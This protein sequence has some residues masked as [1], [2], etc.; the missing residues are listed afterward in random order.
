MNILTGCRRFVLMFANVH[1]KIW[2]AQRLTKSHL[3]LAIVRWCGQAV[4]WP[5]FNF[6]PCALGNSHDKE[7]ERKR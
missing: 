3:I 4:K 5:L 6:N 1:A 2:C 7:Y